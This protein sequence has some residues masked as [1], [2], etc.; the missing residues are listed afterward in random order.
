[1][2][3][4]RKSL[5]FSAIRFTLVI[6]CAVVFGLGTS[7]FSFAGSGS[8][9]YGGISGGGGG[10]PA[11]AK[12]KVEKAISM[13]HEAFSQN[14][15]GSG[16]VGGGENVAS[17]ASLLGYTT[18]KYRSKAIAVMRKGL[19]IGTETAVT[20]ASSVFTSFIGTI[21]DFAV[22]VT[23]DKPSRELIMGGI[24]VYEANKEKGIQ[25]LG[26]RGIGEVNAQKNGLSDLFD[27][28]NKD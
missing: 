21:G 15:N 2:S 5:P 1:M 23:T 28:L 20:K 3:K 7:S 25:G 11:K 12:A 22:A 13:R 19:D 18:I 14:D 10:F 27:E 6:V 26:I 4:F 8:A 17:V 24:E 16:V 9:G